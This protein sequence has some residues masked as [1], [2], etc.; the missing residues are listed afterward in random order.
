MKQNVSTVGVDLA[1]KIFH[2]VGTDT[3]GKIVWRKQ[4]TRRALVPFMT[5]LPPVTIGME[6]IVNLTVI[7]AKRRGRVGR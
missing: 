6:G 4:L 1:I 7:S 3:A 5:Q 2:L